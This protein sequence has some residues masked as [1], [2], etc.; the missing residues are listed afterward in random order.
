MPQMCTIVDDC[1]YIAE[2]GLKQHLKGTRLGFGAARKLSKS[3][4]NSCC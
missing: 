4:E 1:T 3:V 2:S